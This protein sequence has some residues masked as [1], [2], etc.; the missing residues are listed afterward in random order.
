MESLR[1][2]LDDV[3]P[4]P[5]GWVHAHSVNEA[6][7]LIEQ[8]DCTHASLD[9]DL[10][11]YTE[12]GGEGYALVLWMAEHDCWP[13]QGIRIHSANV[14]GVRRMLGVIDRYGPYPKGYSNERGDW[15]TEI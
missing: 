9:H 2:W 13:P 1:L 4:A 5:P 11:E 8:G 3:R 6:I 15:T 12:D 10:G 14:V 7:R